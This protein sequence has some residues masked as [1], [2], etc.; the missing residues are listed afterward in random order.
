[1][2]V[3]EPWVTLHTILSVNYT[4]LHKILHV[5]V[6]TLKSEKRNLRRRQDILFSG[7]QAL[8][9]LWTQLRLGRF[10][11]NTCHFLYFYLSLDLYQ[12][13]YSSHRKHKN[14]FTWTVHVW[15]V[16]QMLYILIWINH[17]HFIGQKWHMHVL[18]N[19]TFNVWKTKW[20]RFM[21]ECKWSM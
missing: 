8:P 14:L 6:Y 18:N 7:S 17:Q 16:A 4:L 2:E 20:S 15:M 10:I 21:D 1:M 19:K 3:T 13:C 12:W 11:K 5:L 9:L